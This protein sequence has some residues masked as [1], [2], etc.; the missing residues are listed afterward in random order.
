MTVLLIMITIVFNKVSDH[1]VA[2]I[3]PIIVLDKSFY[4]LRLYDGHPSRLVVMNI[5]DAIRV[6]VGRKAF[7]IKN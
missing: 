7:L 6:S 1:V 3:V 5:L 4:V 2:I